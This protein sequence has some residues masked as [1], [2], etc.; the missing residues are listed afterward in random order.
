MGRSLWPARSE[1]PGRH[2]PTHSRKGG[3][4]WWKFLRSGN[5][6]R[7]AFLLERCNCRM[8]GTDGRSRY[9][10]PSEGYTHS[11]IVDTRNRSR[12]NSPSTEASGSREPTL[13][14]G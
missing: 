4:S 10:S 6:R 13:L 14:E 8:G 1:P 2:R 3:G 7:Y 11:K 9:G 5:K 12:R